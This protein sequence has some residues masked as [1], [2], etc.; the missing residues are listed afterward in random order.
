MN[1]IRTLM[2]FRTR[3]LVFTITILAA[4]TMVSP[5]HATFPGQ[6]GKIVFVS[7]RSG[8]WQL[9]TIDPDATNIAQITNLPA[10]D[11]DGWFPSFSPDAKQIA[12]C[13][14][15]ENAVEIFV[16]NS[17]GSGIKQLTN[18]GSFDCAPRWSP[19]GNYIVFAQNFIPTNETL[20][21]VM[22]SDGTGPKR[23]LTNGDFRFWGAFAPF[24][25]PDGRDIVFE[26][27]RG[28]LVSAAWVM[29]G[30]GAQPRAFTPAG[31]EA[32][33]ADISPNGRDILVMNHL[34][35]ILPTALF[36]TDIYG[37]NIRPITHLDNVHD[38]AGSYSPDGTKIVFYSDRLNSPFTYDLFTMNADGSAI[39]RIATRVGTC[40]DGNCVDATWGPKPSK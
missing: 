28:G 9:Y 21:S 13:Y 30:D 33:A 4:L 27:Q 16:I 23:T 8:S 31:L 40:P 34:N 6:N 22:R 10:T 12:F 7:D 35:T 25:T 24:Y 11:F 15:S 17:D 38:Q 39:N 20:I 29:T 1:R 14:P 3:F 37:N 2:H 5:A 32:A 18:D 26:S 36:V 19:D